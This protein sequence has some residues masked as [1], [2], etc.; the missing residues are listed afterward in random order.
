[1]DD[2][3]VLRR[4]C[5]VVKYDTLQ[6]VILNLEYENACGGL[7]P[8]EEEVLLTIC[9]EA[10]TDCHMGT[11]MSFQIRRSHNPEIRDLFWSRFEEKIDEKLAAIGEDFVHVE[12]PEA[13]N[14]LNKVQLNKI[15]RLA[16]RLTELASETVSTQQELFARRATLQKDLMFALGKVLGR[17]VKALVARAAN[18]EEKINALL[19]QPSQRSN[20]LRCT[21]ELLT[22]EKAELEE[23]VSKLTD[24]LN[25][26][27]AHKQRFLELAC[28]KAD[29]QRQM[30][31]IRQLKEN[32]PS[33]N[34]ALELHIWRPIRN[35][36][37]PTILKPSEMPFQSAM[38]P[39][40][41]SLRGKQV[42]GAPT[43]SGVSPKKRTEAEQHLI[44]ENRK[45]ALDLFNA[46]VVANDRNVKIVTKGALVHQSLPIDS[47]GGFFLD[48]PS[49]SQS[50]E[51]VHYE[52]SEEETDASDGSGGLGQQRRKKRRKLQSKQ[53]SV[54]P[55][56]SL[57]SEAPLLVPLPPD[58]EKPICDECSREFDDSYLLHN[59]DCQVCDG[60][61]DSKGIHTLV[62]RSTAKERY[63]LTDVDLDVREPPLRRIYKKNPRHSSWGDMQLFLEAQVAARSLEIWG[64][65]AKVEAER[66]S[67]V[68]KRERA[69][70]R[71][72]QKRVKE[73][74]IQ[75]RSSLYAKKSVPHEHTFG[76][77]VYDEKTGTYSKSCTSCGC[78]MSFE[79]M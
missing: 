38:Q 39:E 64:S 41:N 24:L 15:C 73:L 66:A 25:T 47:G 9:R 51:A 36:G 17:E 22:R 78:V 11:S 10:W 43:S 44:D 3:L 7:S 67:R 16:T 49:L 18:L 26:Y 27:D 69:K 60:C 30:D 68:V 77:E 75:V 32:V 14:Q 59:F 65:E 33:A 74:R 4:L 1:M 8:N 57:P 45:K 42:E 71:G 61:R 37:S 56:L 50:Q 76:P 28:R 40:S 29:A 20:D 46:R 23:R 48:P 79:K 34:F 12:D 54:P 21:Y 70:L 31:F 2:N 52:K 62:T 5:A 72:F 13:I 63:L 55:P 6:E 53:P 19:L 58:E 35:G